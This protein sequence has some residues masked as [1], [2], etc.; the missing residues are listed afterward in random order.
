MLQKI[1]IVD[2][3]ASANTLLIIWEDYTN[4]KNLLSYY[5]SD[6]GFEINTWKILFNFCWHFVLSQKKNTVGLTVNFT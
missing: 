1:C 6:T 2:T 4:S 3:N 5:W